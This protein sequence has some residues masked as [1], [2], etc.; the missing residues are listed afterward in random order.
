M[1][2]HDG[3]YNIIAIIH[4]AQKLIQEAPKVVLRRVLCH[5]QPQPECGP[6]TNITHTL[7][8]RNLGGS[9]ITIHAG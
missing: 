9:A 8:A 6:E 4:V 2:S 7:A 5:L 1:F 3:P